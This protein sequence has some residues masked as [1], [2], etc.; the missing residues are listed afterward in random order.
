MMQFV[1]RFVNLKHMQ[2][3]SSVKHSKTGARI[4]YAGVL[5]YALHTNFPFHMFSN[6]KATKLEYPSD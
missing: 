3:C 6:V 4:T 5:G 2:R 1:E